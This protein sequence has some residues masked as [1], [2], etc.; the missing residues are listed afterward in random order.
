MNWQDEIIKR[1]QEPLAPI[2]KKPMKALYTFR[3][4]SDL[5]KRLRERAE[6]KGTTVTS[7]II[8]AIIL[9]LKSD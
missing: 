8:E 2:F 6:K 3:I 7:Q 4:E 9:H 5:L 1:E